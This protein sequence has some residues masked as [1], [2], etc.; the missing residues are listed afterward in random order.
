MEFGI[1]IH[2]CVYNPVCPLVPREIYTP[3]PPTSHISHSSECV[4]K[5]SERICG[6]Y[7]GW[8]N[9]SQTCALVLCGRCYISISYFS[10]SSS[11]KQNSLSDLVAPFC[12]ASCLLCRIISW[13]KSQSIIHNNH[14]GNCA[15]PG[16]SVWKPDWCQGKLNFTCLRKR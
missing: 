11:F 16:R 12:L 8:N 10:S 14:E 13:N 9:V 3:P 5:T 6:Y 15:Y 4:A 7:C 1:L 2:C